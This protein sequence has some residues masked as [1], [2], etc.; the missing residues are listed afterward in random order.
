MG[1]MVERNRSEVFRDPSIE[2]VANLMAKQLCDR[3][4]YHE[5]DL[6]AR[7][8]QAL[9]EAMNQQLSFS[10]YR[11]MS[12]T[13]DGAL[14]DRGGNQYSMHN[15]LTKI[16]LHGNFEGMKA[17]LVTEG[18]GAMTRP[19]DSY[20]LIARVIEDLTSSREGFGLTFPE[21]GVINNKSLREL[22][23]FGTPVV[24]LNHPAEIFERFSVDINPEPGKKLASRGVPRV[25]LTN[26]YKNHGH[27]F[28]MSIDIPDE[29]GKVKPIFEIIIARDN[30]CLEEAI[31][32]KAQIMEKPRQLMD[33]AMSDLAIEAAK[34]AVES[35]HYPY[36]AAY[37]TFDGHMLVARNNTSRDDEQQDHAEFLLM[38]ELKSE[39]DRGIL[40]SFMEPC[41]SCV[42][43]IVA[44]PVVEVNY[45][46]DQDESWSG[47]RLPMF[48]K[49]NR[50][51]EYLV[52]QANKIPIAL[53]LLKQTNSEK[54]IF[55]G[56]FK[57]TIKINKEWYE[58]WIHI[59][60]KEMNRLA[61][62]HGRSI[63]L[64]PRWGTNHRLL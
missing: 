63:Y 3:V 61:L 45:I 9:G 48:Q 8:L 46:L 2:E 21:Y 58:K 32:A 57:H 64:N 60:K 31:E 14:F 22:I 37:R 15:L 54:G 11:G 30:E 18:F 35:G 33:D 25:T 56:Q 44:K 42:Q 38:D 59:R 5:Y 52:R 29:N 47:R 49:R 10:T 16:M 62:I 55:R 23:G 12:R 26:K 50:G 34:I 19:N 24:K 20:S 39:S 43:K 27:H 40:Y 36:G 7:P 4:G 17:E 28:S 6:V 13:S 1:L 41:P 51:D 53:N